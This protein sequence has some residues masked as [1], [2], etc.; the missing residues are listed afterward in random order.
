MLLGCCVGAAWA[1]LGRCSA[2]AWPV[3]HRNGL[4]IARVANTM[5][6]PA[7]CVRMA[8]ATRATCEPLRQ[9]T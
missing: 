7:F 8:R 2:H 9:Q 5:R 3:R 6:T 4:Q 1:L